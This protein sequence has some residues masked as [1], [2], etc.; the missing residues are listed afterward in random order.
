MP[1]RS[2]KQRAYLR[3]NHPGVYARWMKKYGAKIKKTARAAK[4][5]KR[6]K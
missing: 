1:F 3:I 4:A 5:A 6:G 2:A